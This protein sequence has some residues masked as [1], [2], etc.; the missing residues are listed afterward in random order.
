M[1]L[2]KQ[3]V[4]AGCLLALGG[5]A[6]SPR[7]V[8]LDF[9]ENQP[10]TRTQVVDQ[11]GP[12]NSSFEADFVLTYWLRQSKADY[13][14]M[15]RTTHNLGWDGINYDLVLAFDDTGILQQHRLVLIRPPEH[16]H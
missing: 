12:P 3:F 2:K 8:S 1:Q 16:A 10:V 13:F 6:T 7:A 5:C 15:P 9:L 14:V 4:V 11:L